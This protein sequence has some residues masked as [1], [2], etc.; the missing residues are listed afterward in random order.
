MSVGKRRRLSRPGEGGTGRWVTLTGHLDGLGNAAVARAPH[1]ELPA[2]R[3]EA[4]AVHVTRAGARPQPQPHR[5]LLHLGDGEPA[6]VRRVGVTVVSAG[7]EL[8]RRGCLR[9]AGRGGGI[10]ATGPEGARTRSAHLSLVGLLFLLV[11][12]VAGECGVRG[13]FHAL[14]CYGGGQTRL[15]SRLRFGRAYAV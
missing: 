4:A 5:P 7:E 15:L 1:V 14:A 12:F 3:A 11:L 10:F 2:L 6:A 9:A 8:D 13:I